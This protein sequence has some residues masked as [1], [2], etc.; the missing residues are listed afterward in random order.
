MSY[1]SDNGNQLTLIINTNLSA[2]HKL[3][4]FLPIKRLPVVFMFRPDP[5]A[6][7]CICSYSQDPFIIFI[8]HPRSDLCKCDEPVDQCMSTLSSG[9]RTE[10]DLLIRRLPEGL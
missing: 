8:T 4:W 7:S 9:E 6:P 5:S 2:N 1:G 3:G 10:E